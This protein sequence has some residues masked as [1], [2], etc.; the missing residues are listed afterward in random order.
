MIYNIIWIFSKDV[1][2]IILSNNGLYITS[3]IMIHF[4]GCIEAILELVTMLSIDPQTY[5]QAQERRPLAWDEW[6]T[7]YGN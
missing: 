5:P 7:Q 3:N 2:Y 6:H 1:P 4:I